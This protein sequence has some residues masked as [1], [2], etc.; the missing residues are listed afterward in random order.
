MQASYAVIRYIP[1]ILREEF[2]NVGVILVCPEIQYQAVLALPDFSTSQGKL[3][4]FDDADGR[5]VRHAITKLRHA[6]EEKRFDEY[7]SARAAPEGILTVSGLIELSA[8]YHNNIRLTEPR[9]VL[10]VNPEASLQELYSMFIGVQAPI[11]TAVKVTRETMR[12]E[13][14]KVFNHFGLFRRYPDKVEQKVKPL[15]WASKVD[16]A[17][18]NGAMHFYQLVPF[19]D[20]DNTARIVGNYLTVARDVRNPKIRLDTNFEHAE[21]AVFGYY[22]PEQERV[23]E[24]EAIK[25]RLE[26][27]DIKLLDY[28]EDSPRVAQKISRELD[29]QSGTMHVN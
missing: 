11:E 27:E 28:L 2:I 1:S 10:T 8:T 5:F 9:T 16:I 26:R 23:K 21:F 29:A 20:A 18:R 6:A 12:A 3:S 24:I 25:K 4:A 14:V 7:V 17:Y 19:T 13:V 15:P 22:A